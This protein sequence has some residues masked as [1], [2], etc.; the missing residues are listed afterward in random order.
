MYNLFRNRCKINKLFN[1]IMIGQ[2]HTHS[3]LIR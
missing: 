1:T 2:L 3:R